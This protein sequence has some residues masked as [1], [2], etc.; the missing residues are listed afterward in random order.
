MAQTRF[1]E[2]GDHTQAPLPPPP[3]HLG[4]Q[5]IG[6]APILGL[7]LT[8]RTANK[9]ETKLLP[10]ASVGGANVM[11]AASHEATGSLELK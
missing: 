3:N 4:R 5:N 7:F 1:V 9:G 10:T 8:H 6:G 11:T 2:T